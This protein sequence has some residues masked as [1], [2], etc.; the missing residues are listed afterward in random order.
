MINIGGEGVAQA[1]K[2][3]KPLLDIA[4]AAAAFPVWQT[5]NIP[6]RQKMSQQL[7]ERIKER[8]DRYVGT[9][10]HEAGKLLREAFMLGLHAELILWVRLDAAMYRMDA[11]GTSRDNKWRSYRTDS[12]GVLSVISVRTHIVVLLCIAGGALKH[13][14]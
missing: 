5:I 1:P 3:D 11:L 8:A 9:V 4:I 2:A 14:L 6:D 7:A 12:L 13:D 10:I